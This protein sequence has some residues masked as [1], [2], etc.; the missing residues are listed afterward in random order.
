MRKTL[1][2]ALLGTAVALAGFALPSG[3]AAAQPATGDIAGQYIVVLDDHA[4]A[5]ALSSN[6][7]R[8]Y[9]AKVLSIYQHAL[10]GYA[11][12]MSS[13]AAARVARE[14]GV[15]WVQPDKKVTATAQTLPTGIDRVDAE[16]SPTAAINGVDTRVD[17]DVAVIDSGVELSHPDLNVFT[18]GATTCAKGTRTANDGFGHGTHVAG[19]IGAL[20]NDSSV[21]GVAPGARMWPVRVLN[22]QGSGTVS[23]VVCGIDYVTAHASEIEVA[24]M[25]LGTGGSDDHNCGNTNRD[26]WHK[27]ICASVAAGVTYVVSAG[28]DHADA[29]GQ[30]PA[31]YDEVITVSALTDFDGLSGGLGAPTCG[32]DVDDTLANFSN[33]GP[34]IDLIAPGSCILSTSLGGSTTVLSGTSMASPHVAGGA[35]LYAATHPGATPDGIKTALQSVGTVDWTWSSLEDPDGIQ[36]KLLNVSTL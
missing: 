23:T 13:A 31:S 22:N 25:S 30:I 5:M 24:N 29:A 36:E 35:A 18:A 1:H 19:T 8:A 11:A 26:A 16:L 34:D 6:H 4:N 15:L 33:Y 2:S 17:V 10:H 3:T 28:N 32:P 14:P 12:R 7:A 27:A 20:D 21:V 9:G